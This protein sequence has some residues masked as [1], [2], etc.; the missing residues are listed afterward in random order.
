MGLDV[1]PQRRDDDRPGLGVDAQQPGQPLVQLE[2]QRL[3][4]QEEQDRALDVLVAGTL[5]LR[6]ERDW[7]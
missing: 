4:I 6:G 7:F 1:L 2:L 3:V 5:H